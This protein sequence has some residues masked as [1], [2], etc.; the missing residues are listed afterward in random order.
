MS[1]FPAVELH[2]K[3]TVGQLPARAGQVII[4]VL[5]VRVR[6]EL[7]GAFLNDLGLIVNEAVL[8]VGCYGRIVLIPVVGRLLI[9]ITSIITTINT[10]IITIPARAWS[11]LS[12]KSCR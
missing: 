12:P 8:G 2:C 9:A 7:P 1:F 4:F 11:C 5:I 10:T 3:E 6:D